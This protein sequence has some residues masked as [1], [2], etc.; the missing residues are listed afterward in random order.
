[1]YSTV[2]ARMA[3]RTCAIAYGTTSRP[4]NRP[5][6]H[7]PKLTAGLIWHPEIRPIAYAMVSSVSPK[8]KATPV[9]PI[10]S[11]EKPAASTA[12][13]HPTKT[14]QNVPMNSAPTRRDRLIFIYLLYVLLLE[15]DYRIVCH[16]V[17]LIPPKPS[18]PLRTSVL[19][20]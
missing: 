16:R 6:A 19:K 1:M 18:V 10:P 13:P 14:S 11:L 5:P 12:L 4:G 2:A 17:A 9:K 15:V 3:P 7:N 8:A 20:P